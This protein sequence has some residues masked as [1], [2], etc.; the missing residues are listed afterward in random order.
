MEPAPRIPSDLLESDLEDGSMRLRMSTS[1]YPVDALYAAAF[2]FLDRCWVLLDQEDDRYVVTL[3]PKVGKA[4][5][6]AQQKDAV[7]GEFANA[8]LAAAWR[9]RLTT[10]NRGPI[11][12]V[13][14]TAFAGAV[15]PPSLDELE[16]FDFS[17]EP[18]ED[19]LGIAES[20]E[21]KYGK[22]PKAEESE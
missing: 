5:F 1:L 16:E 4:P 2:Q 6:D 8:V 19:P 10:A 3:V 21:S 18:F 14:K 13:M 22:K 12:L 9:A 17:D 15:G 20:W 11:E 7:A